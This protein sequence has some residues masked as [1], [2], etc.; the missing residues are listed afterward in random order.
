[1]VRFDYSCRCLLEYTIMSNAVTSYGITVVIP[2]SSKVK[3]YIA[4]AISAIR[5]ES[6]YTSARCASRQDGT[7]SACSFQSYEHGT[8][9]TNDRRFD[10]LHPYRPMRSVWISNGPNL[11]DTLLPSSTGSGDGCSSIRSTRS[12]RVAAKPRLT[13][14]VVDAPWAS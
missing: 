8:Q 10:A 5:S 4:T 7:A 2:M 11:T 9:I 1:M 12:T 13:L 14:A 3:P 6:L